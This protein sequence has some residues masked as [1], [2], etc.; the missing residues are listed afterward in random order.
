MSGPDAGPAATG[1]RGGGAVAVLLGVAAVF[2]AQY[3]WVRA[4]NFGGV[5]EWLCI[6]LASRGVLGVPYANR[7]LVLLWTAIAAHAWPHHLGAYWLVHG[8]YLM[9]AGLLS[10]W[11]AWRL[12][13]GSRGVALLAGVFACT[14]APLDFMWLDTVLLAGY[15]GFAVATMLAIVLLV[16]SWRAVN[17]PLLA[18]GAGVA[19]SPLWA[20]RVSFPSW[21]PPPCSCRSCS[22]GPPRRLATWLLVWEAV[23]VAAGALLL[24]PL[25]LGGRATRRQ[26]RPRPAPGSVC[27]G[28]VRILALHVRPSVSSP[29]SELIVPGVGS[30]GPCSW[31]SGFRHP[32]GIGGGQRRSAGP[33]PEAGARRAGPGR[34]RE[35]GLRPQ[36][37]HPPARPTQVLS[38]PGVGLALASAIALVASLLP[39]AGGPCRGHSRG[40]G[41]R[42][43][44][45][46][47]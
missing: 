40:L 31:V 38:A 33:A 2:W 30:R 37:S 7:P 41:R 10:A 39:V 12:V 27:A 20:S 29:P 14:W 11:L 35:H 15:P 43:W 1:G 45:G 46:D 25:L 13:P 16:E 34:A 17:A 26:P 42:G 24:G 5:D 32:P 21:P 47:G 22:P 44:D 8:L 3:A 23:V 19:F 28:L 18:L 9:G 4:T 36:P 6:D